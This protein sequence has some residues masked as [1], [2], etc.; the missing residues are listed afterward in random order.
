MATK[1]MINSTIAALFLLGIFTFGAQ[2]VTASWATPGS[3]NNIGTVEKIDYRHQVITIDDDQYR[4]TP[5]HM[6]MMKKTEIKISSNIRFN[7]RIENSG[8]FINWLVNTKHEM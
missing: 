8:K 7:Y 1:R 6:A 4:F 2:V 3:I 5:R